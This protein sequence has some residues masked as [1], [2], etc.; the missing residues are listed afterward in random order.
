MRSG[1]GSPMMGSVHWE[2][3]KETRAISLSLCYLSTQ[4]EVAFCK[5][6]RGPSSEPKWALWSRISSPRTG[7]I[8]VCHLSHPV[9]GVSSSSLSWLGQKGRG[10]GL[11]YTCAKMANTQAG[12]VMRGLAE[13][14]ERMGMVKEP[15]LALTLPV[16]QS[17][18]L[19][20]QPNISVLPLSF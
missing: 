15:R 11:K 3:E 6:G 9:S 12:A 18:P 14:G 1:G 8:G 16:L 4:Q 19:H 10:K 2:K 5:A 7:D 20:L 13:L 17:H